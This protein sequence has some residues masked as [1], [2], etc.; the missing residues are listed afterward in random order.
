M[1]NAAGHHPGLSLH[2]GRRPFAALA[3]VSVALLAAC[4]GNGTTPSAV[5][6]S[7]SDAPL[8]TE[9]DAA[10]A[11]TEREASGPKWGG[12]L[13]YDTTLEVASWKP[14]DLTTTRGG[15]DR[16]M[17][18]YDTLLK[19]LP[20]GS[21]GPNMADIASEDGITWRMTLRDGIEFTDGTPLNAAAVVFNITEIMNP[22]NGS[23]QRR[24]VSDIEEM[25]VLDSLTV[26]FV[27]GEP[28]G[29]FPEAFTTTPGM[30]ASPTAYQADP[31]A[32]G[33]NPVGAGPFMVDSHLR[34]STLK[35]VR[36]PNYWDQPKPYLDA[37]EF[38]ILPDPLTR[39][40]AVT[41]R[42]TDISANAPSVQAAVLRADSDD[43]KV[44]TTVE[45]G[46]HAVVANHDRPPFDDIRMLQAISLAWDYDVVNE[47]L[48]QGAWRDP[49]LVCPPF[50]PNQP[51]CLPGVWPEPDPARARELVEEYV[52]EGN[53]LGSYELLTITSRVTEAQFIQQSLRDIG[54]NAELT[55]LAV[56]EFI[57]R[58]ANGEFDLSWHRIAPFD[59]IPT[60]YYRYM[61]S[62]GRHAQKGPPNLELD[63]A[64]NRAAKAISADERVEASQR[65]QEI[66]AEELNYIFFGPSVDGLVGKSDVV[67]G[68][69]YP[70]G[71]LVVAQD[72][73]LDR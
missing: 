50:S 71:A 6:S 14:A 65:V 34:D 43:L 11:D 10:A 53:A 33:R 32:F 12:T 45:S 63:E 40:Q 26:E 5:D 39:A 72:I 52:D 24:V 70:G 37:V 51:D 25:N 30:I 42:E 57:G 54:I 18:V 22:D 31:D 27:L 7:E 36:N 66:N 60:S 68:D 59:R 73:W 62:T 35:L 29:N 48:L 38:R 3:L 69:R 56:P 67:L 23:V 15:G 21:V 9:T 4:G 64:M 2:R 49:S 47:S 8:S 20:G 19:L 28:D 46:A 16:G 61:D 17:F 55:I 13:R 41:A 44:F 58:L 1:T